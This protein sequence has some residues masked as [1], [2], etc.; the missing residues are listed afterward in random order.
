ME[1]VPIFDIVGE[2]DDALGAS[3]AAG[4]VFAWL[5]VAEENVAA[6]P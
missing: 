2:N 4:V 1:T 5:M 6:L 3:F